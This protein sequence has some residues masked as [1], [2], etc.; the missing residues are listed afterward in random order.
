[1]KLFVYADESGTFDSSHYDWFTYGGVM[2]CGLEAMQEMAR[3]YAGLEAKL[4]GEDESLA[5]LDELKAKYLDFHNRKRLYNSLSIPGVH[6]FGVIVNQAKVFPNIY[7]D[8]RSRQRFIDYA[9]KRAIKESIRCALAH[10]GG[11]LCPQLTSSKSLSTSILRRLMVDTP[12]RSQLM[13]SCAMGCS[14]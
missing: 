10:E 2:C 12:S 3:R 1:M 9:L 5:C 8:Q 6:R 14:V 11:S 4:R 13:K 7:G